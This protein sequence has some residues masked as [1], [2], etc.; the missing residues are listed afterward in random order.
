MD[1]L[2]ELLDGY[3]PHDHIP[4]AVPHCAP[5]AG[6]AM[7]GVRC[8]GVPGVVGMWVGAWVGYTGYYQIPSQDPYLDHIRPQGPTYGQMK[9]I[10]LYFMRFLG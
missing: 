7:A 3:E 4:P 6:T 2:S 10:S 9:A 8:R 5:D 1:I